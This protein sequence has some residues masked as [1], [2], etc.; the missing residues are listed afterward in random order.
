MKVVVALFL[1]L[2]LSGCV[3]WKK[4][5]E[6]QNQI[7]DTSNT[8]SV[9]VSGDWVRL[10]DN[11]AENIFITKD[12]PQLQWV[13]VER[14]DTETPF[15]VSKQKITEK[16]LATELADFY[17]AEL[18]VEDAEISIERDNLE[19]FVHQGMDGFR[20]AVSMV[21]SKGLRYKMLSYGLIKEG[22]AYI[23]SYFAPRLHYFDRD[24]EEYESLVK[25]FRVR[26]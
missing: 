24:V 19:P 13:K 22:K 12:G 6:Q 16:T 20:M 14:F 15:Q 7:S 26:S 5:P 18:R 3:T 10:G 9:M 2:A 4:L 17:L 25:S 1:S 8:Y 21:S 23:F 11:G